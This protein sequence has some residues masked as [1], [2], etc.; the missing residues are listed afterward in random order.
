M[1]SSLN[2]AEVRFVDGR[3]SQNVYYDDVLSRH[4]RKDILTSGLALEQAGAMARK[5]FSMSGRQRQLDPRQATATR[6]HEIR[7]AAAVRQFSLI[8]PV[9]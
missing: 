4:P 1:K 8:N 3:T 5:T 9:N 6:N 7:A 2:V